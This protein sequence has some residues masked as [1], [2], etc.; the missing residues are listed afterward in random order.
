MQGVRGGGVKSN[1]TLLRCYDVATFLL[2]AWIFGISYEYG[3]AEFTCRDRPGDGP[4]C[5]AAIQG[6][7]ETNVLI[8]IAIRLIVGLVVAYIWKRL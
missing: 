8:G 2:A 1:A 4:M 3:M 6:A 7:I 5:E